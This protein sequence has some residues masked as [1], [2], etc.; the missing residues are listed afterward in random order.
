MKDEKSKCCGR[1]VDTYFPQEV[2][3]V[4]I[5]STCVCH[6]SIKEEEATCPHGAQ[7]G[8]CLVGCHTPPTKGTKIDEIDYSDYSVANFISK[9]MN[10]HGSRLRWL[11]GIFYD[12]QEKV[13]TVIEWM[14]GIA[15]AQRS[16]ILEELEGMI[17]GEKWKGNPEFET[18]A[19]FNRNQTLNTVLSI[20]N[21]YKKK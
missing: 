9:Y 16:L 17:E 15:Q 5:N 3:K 14:E 2:E 19:D 10:D 8:E 13:D 11:R 7:E 18:D 12:E 21:S 20:I 4:C 6:S 1:C